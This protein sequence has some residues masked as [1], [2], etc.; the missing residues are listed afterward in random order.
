MNA[1]MVITTILL[2]G[3]FFSSFV[4]TS[5]AQR[6]GNADVLL[7]EIYIE[8]ADPQT[9][10]PVSIQS[11]VYNAGTDSTKSVTDVVTVGYFVNG[12]LVRIAELPNIEP[13][14]KNGIL[15]SSGPMFTATDG[16]HVITVI[17]NYHDTLS[18]LTDNSANNIVQRMFSI[19]N[20]L[21]S[22][23]LF[24]IF[25]EYDPHTKM[26]DVTING[27]LSSPDMKFLPAQIKLTIDNSNYVMLVDS[28]GLFSFDKSIRTSEKI[29]SVV[30]TVEEN[31]PLLGS[32]YFASIYPVQLESNSVWSFQIQ[33]PSELYNFH[34]SS[35][36]I[37][38]YE[39]S[40]N[41]II[42][43][44]TDHLL[45]SE[46]YRDAV[47]VTL[48][49]GTY[50]AEVYLD[51][52]LIHVVKTHL[53][54]NM[55]KTSGLLIPE[56]SRVQFQVL[57]DNG[58]P[59]YGVTVYGDNFTLTTNENGLTDWVDILPTV[60]DNDQYVVTAILTDGKII[61]SDPFSVV[62]GEQ[63]VIQVMEKV[64]QR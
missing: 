1:S 63:N 25:Q 8:P 56:T 61:S 13:G 3:I 22:T 20:P 31:Y 53:K 5:S 12:D 26:Q 10:D 62:L 41:E 58:E 32:S 11:I 27:N 36:I 60:S 14:V 33:N 28:D 19:G 64:K 49:S 17:L 54:E 7:S 59:A 23:V 29:I 40:Y 2:F 30:I 45:P 51:G 57:S 24:E 9:G 39:E 46:K 37:V 50:I 44:N 55:I 35:A 48:P 38:I 15:L 6:I 34:D 52:R 16:N 43:I 21:P 42:K 18:H 4:A 47:L